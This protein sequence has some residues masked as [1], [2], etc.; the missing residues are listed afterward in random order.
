MTQL[1]QAARGIG[2][3]IFSTFG[4]AILFALLFGLVEVLFGGLAMDNLYRQARFALGDVVAQ[5]FNPWTEAAAR[6]RALSGLRWGILLGAI[7]GAFGGLVAA[8]ESGSRATAPT[9]LTGAAAGLCAAILIVGGVFHLTPADGSYLVL[10]LGAFVGA[11]LSLVID[12]R[13]GRS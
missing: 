6:S 5:L 10:A 12:A 8:I 1:L 9:I 7:V 3:V 11:V 4:T 13:I 2:L